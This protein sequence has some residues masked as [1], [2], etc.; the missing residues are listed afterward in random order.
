MEY[1]TQDGEGSC[2]S[3]AETQIFNIAAIY[4]ARTLYIY[5]NSSEMSN[6]VWNESEKP[7]LVL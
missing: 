7:F 5:N 4:S 3:H 2:T 1:K 6:P